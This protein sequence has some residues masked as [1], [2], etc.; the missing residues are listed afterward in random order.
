[1]TKT[2]F[3]LLKDKHA[4]LFKLSIID[5]EHL[6]QPMFH[7]TLGVINPVRHIKSGKYISTRVHPFIIQPSGT[8]KGEVMTLHSDLLRAMGRKVFYGLKATEAALVMQDTQVQVGKQTVTQVKPGMLESRDA[9]FFDEGRELMS[10]AN[11]Y[12]DVRNA[13]NMAMNES[14]KGGGLVSKALKSQEIEFTSHMSLCAGSVLTGEMV[15]SVLDEGFYQ[16]SY[17]SFRNFTEREILNMQLE[18]HRLHSIDKP[19]ITNII[20]DIK[21][22]YAMWFDDMKLVYKSATPCIRFAA[23][24]DNEIRNLMEDYWKQNISETYTDDKQ[25]QLMTFL[26]RN[27]IDKATKIAVQRAVFQLKPEIEVED[28][29]FGLQACEFNMQSVKDLLSTLTVR[30]NESLASD[31]RLNALLR[32]IRLKDMGWKRQDLLDFL[33]KKRQANEWDISV[34]STDKLLQKL[35]TDGHVVKLTQGTAGERGFST[36][37]R[38]KPS[39]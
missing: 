2:Y 1:M 15:S 8:G 24:S 34:R 30:S 35:E 12:Q 31:K 39:I 19:Q 13:F 36:I 3:E 28:F 22:T 14:G 20:K 9:L 4:E 6:I 26:T 32:F 27:F 11:Y 7:F 29:E 21:D 10:E 5:N 25:I 18:M 38:A 16:R 37:I 23:N 17:M 33:E